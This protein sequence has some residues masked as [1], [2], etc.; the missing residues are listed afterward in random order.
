MDDSNCSWRQRCRSHPWSVITRECAHWRDSLRAERLPAQQNRCA[1]NFV[2]TGQ[3]RP[4]GACGACRRREDGRLT[5]L[6]ARKLRHL[7]GTKA[8]RPAVLEVPRKPP[9]R[10]EDAAHLART[11][12]RHASVNVSPAA[13]CVRL[14]PERGANA[15]ASTRGNAAARLT[16][17]DSLTSLT[18]LGSAHPS[19]ASCGGV[20][21]Q[22]QHGAHAC[23]RAWN[24]GGCPR[25]R[26][27]Q[28]GAVGRPHSSTP[29]GDHSP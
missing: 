2:T 12:P 4:V 28:T 16:A 19:Q 21:T 6:N 1:V 10:T 24:M 23:S 11:A 13:S 9:S 22:H 20:Q 17:G 29:G 18:T 3:A 14:C 26:Q 27:P 8:V 15:A 25:E 5:H 7:V